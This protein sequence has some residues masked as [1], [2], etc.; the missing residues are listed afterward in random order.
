MNKTLL[1]MLIFLCGCITADEMHGLLTLKHL[2]DNQAHQEKYMKIQEA[3][4]QKLLQY[5]KEEK[6]EPGRSKKW[7]LAAFGEPILTKAIEDGVE[8]KESLMYRHPD[9]FFGSEKVYLFLDGK[10]TLTGWRYEEGY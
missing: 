5:V 4:F 7:I 9:Q 3:K 1:I 10:Q 6:L 2:S 8:A